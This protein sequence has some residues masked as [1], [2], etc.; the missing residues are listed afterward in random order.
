MS[1]VTAEPRLHSVDDATVRVEPLDL[2]G[3]G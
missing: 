3:D 2:V 1:S